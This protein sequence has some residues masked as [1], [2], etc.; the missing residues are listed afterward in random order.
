MNNFLV[1]KSF[2]DHS[3]DCEEL[4]SLGIKAFNLSRRQITRLYVK[5]PGL[6]G[7]WQYLG[8]LERHHDVVSL[9]GCLI[10]GGVFMTVSGLL[11]GDRE[12]RQRQQ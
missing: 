10:L 11:L 1:G 4:D 8:A 5:N 9:W 2:M 7:S 3:L 6:F 12:Q